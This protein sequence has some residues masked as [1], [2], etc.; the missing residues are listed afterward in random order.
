MSAAVALDA[1]KNFLMEAPLFEVKTDIAP[2]IAVA[3]DCRLRV[4]TLSKPNRKGC[5]RHATVAAKA[6]FGTDYAQQRL[7]R[8]ARGTG[9][10]GL[11]TCETLRTPRSRLVSVKAPHLPRRSMLLAHP[12]RGVFIAAGQPCTPF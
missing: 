11:L 6:K 7:P 4:T 2:A 8:R 10:A 12:L 5:S 3:G 9:G 1:I